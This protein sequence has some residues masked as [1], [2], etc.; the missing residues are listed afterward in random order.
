MLQRNQACTTKE[1]CQI[2]KSSL[3]TYF[4]EHFVLKGTSEI[5]AYFTEII[6]HAEVEDALFN[7]IMS[8]SLNC[9]L[10][11]WTS[12]NSVAHVQG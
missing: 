2:K 10:H 5:N 11:T 7:D 12:L 6:K 4:P 9:I 1:L 8:H 3:C